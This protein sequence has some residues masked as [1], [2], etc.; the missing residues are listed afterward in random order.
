M[1]KPLT[2]FAQKG[3]NKQTNTP[4]NKQTNKHSIQI[5][6]NLNENDQAGFCQ[7]HLLF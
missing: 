7:K 2:E 5:L 6:Q 4:T 1:V 3:E